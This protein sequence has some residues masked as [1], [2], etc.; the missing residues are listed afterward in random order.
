M[1]QLSSLVVGKI[2]SSWNYEASTDILVNAVTSMGDE[3]HTIAASGTDSA[4]RVFDLRR[5]DG[6]PHCR[7]ATFSE[8]KV[9]AYIPLRTSTDVSS[10]LK[11][12]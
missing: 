11:F 1:P 5:G 8:P 4:V 7:A 6:T 9:L 12:C 2:V 3:M 10:R